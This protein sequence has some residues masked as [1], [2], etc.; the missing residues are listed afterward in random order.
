M[1]FWLDAQLSPALALWIAETFSISATAVRDLGLRDA[2]DQVLRP[3]PRPVDPVVDD[4][5][6]VDAPAE[7]LGP[8]RVDPDNAAWRHGRTIYRAL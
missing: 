3:A 2:T 5:L 8:A 7:E 4:Q 6:L 1:T